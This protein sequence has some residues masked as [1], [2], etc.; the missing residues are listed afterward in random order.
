MRIETDLVFESIL[1]IS[2]YIKLGIKSSNITFF[3]VA[4]VKSLL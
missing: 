1:Y 2:K 3:M 4:N